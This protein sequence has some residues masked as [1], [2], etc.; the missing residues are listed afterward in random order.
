VELDLRKN[1]PMISRLNIARSSLLIGLLIGLVS[2][3]ESVGHIGN[4]NFLVPAYPLGPSHAW[5]HVFREVCGDV[6]KMAVFLLLF[7]GS[8]RWRTPVAWSICLILMLGYYAPFWIGEPFL[9]AL[10]APIPIAGVAHVAMAVFAFLALASPDQASC[11][12]KGKH[13]DRT[14][15]LL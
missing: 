4:A 13:R 14:V 7:F 10:T 1:N 9:P 6:A 2:W 11:F 5:Y 3:K 15:R 8:D 12:P